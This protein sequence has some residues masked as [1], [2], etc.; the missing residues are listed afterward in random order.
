MILAFPLLPEKVMP[1]WSRK[2]RKEDGKILSFVFLWNSVTW[3]KPKLMFIILK[4][5]SSVFR[6]FYFQNRLEDFWTC[7]HFSVVFQKLD[8]FIEISWIVVFHMFSRAGGETNKQTK[9]SNLECS[10]LKFHF[11]CLY[12]SAFM[13]ILTNLIGKNQHSFSDLNFATYKSVTKYEVCSCKK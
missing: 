1:I 2:G 9:I 7:E 13:A 6:S 11:N 8:L 10:R 4:E 12:S 3:R 5:K